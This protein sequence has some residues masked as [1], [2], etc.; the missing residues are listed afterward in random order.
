VQN[1]GGT[2]TY[3]ICQ[4]KYETAQMLGYSGQPSGLMDPKENAKWAANYLRYQ[5][6]RYGDWCKAIAAYNAGRYNEST[7]M[8]GYPRN[9]KYVNNVKKISTQHF[10][11]DKIYKERSYAQNNGSR[12]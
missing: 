3:G 4:V 5:Q 8:P 1:D 12:L 6:V 9:L 7:V 2:P 10:T 11:C